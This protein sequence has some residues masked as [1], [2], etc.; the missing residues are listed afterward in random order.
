MNVGNFVVSLDFELLW[1]VRDHATHESYGR[2]IVGGREA[3]PRILEL[4]AQHEIRATWA[5]VGF[6]FAEDRDELLASLPPDELRPAYCDPRLSNYSYLDEVGTDE[7][8]D[9]YYFGLSL[10]RFIQQTPGQD[11]GT[12]TLSHF[13]ALEPG[14]MLAAFEADLLAAQALAKR[15]GVALR[16]IVFPR[17]QYDQ[18]HLEICRKVGITSFRGNPTSWAYRPTAGAKQTFARRGLRLLDAHT[19]ILGSHQH[20]GVVGD[21]Q[22]PRDIPASQFLRP[23]SGRLAAL[24]PLHLSTLKRAMTQAAISS[25]IFHLWWHPHNFGRDLESNLAALRQ[26]VRHAL[27]L[28]DSHGMQSANMADLA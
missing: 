1:G 21:D 22:S 9:P 24:H 28:R 17:N 4:F 23:C 6:L 26:V 15:R 3:I 8:R 16:S 27:Q 19:G 2:N 5:T 25:S 10:I 18:K 11:I 12:H 20:Q 14:A 13:Y 7:R